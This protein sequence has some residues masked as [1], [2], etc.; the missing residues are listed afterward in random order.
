VIVAALKQWKFRPATRH[1]RP[2]AAYYVLTVNID[3]S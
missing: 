2:V 3:W 1:G